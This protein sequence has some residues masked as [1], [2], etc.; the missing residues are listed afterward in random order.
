MASSGTGLRAG[1]P[2]IRTRFT[3]L[4]VLIM[5]IQK[6]RRLAVAGLCVLSIAIGNAASAANPYWQDLSSRNPAT[7]GPAPSAYR[8][9]VLDWNRLDTAMTTS[10]GGV[11]FKLDLPTP[12][13]GTQTF[14]LSDSGVMPAELAARYPSIR[15]YIGL[16]ADGTSARIDISELGLQASVYAKEG[17]WLVRPEMLG[18]GDHYLSFRRADLARGDH[19]RCATHGELE[20]TD[21]PAIEQ[22]PQPLTTTGASRRVYR[23]AVAANHQYVQAVA[24][25]MSPPQTPT[26]A[27]GLAAIVAA[28]NRVNQPYS[29]DFSIRMSLIATNDLLI[30]PDA[31]GDTFGSEAFNDGDALNQI[32]AAITGIVGVA[33]YDI[34]HLFTTGAG[35]VAGLGVVCGTSKG[36]GTTGLSSGST[37]QSDVFYIDYVAHE[38]GHQFGGNHTFNGANLPNN[39]CGSGNRTASSAY[40]PGSGSTIQA[41]AGICGVTMNLQL[42]SDPYFH[43]RSLAQMG[44]YTSTGNGG[45]CPASVVNPNAAPTI[46]PLPSY[47][48]PASTPYVLSGTASSTAAGATLTYAWEQYDLGPT[49][50]AQANTDLAVDPGTG[51]IQRSWPPTTAPRRF[52]PRVENLL[53]DTPAFGEILPTTSRLLTYRLTV[54]DNASDGG[55]SNST[56]QILTVVNTAGPF[57]VTAPL[58]TTPW[59][60][61]TGPATQTVTWN[62]AGTDLPP[63]SCA[64]VS[65]DL[66]SATS[67]DLIRTVLL[68]SSVPNSGSAVVTVPNVQQAAARVRVSCANNVFFN[69]SPAFAVTGSDLLFKNGFDSL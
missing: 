27:L 36:R 47:T 37:L 56:D 53:S 42:H 14:T 66:V 1:F 29:Q 40:E 21:Q 10:A 49:S 23:A 59:N 35:G 19:F 61:V 30:F 22:A 60:F 16:A 20:L 24:S 8:A 48:I 64:N 43:A 3:S 46:A 26:V 25:A 12:A 4:G 31:S 54:R 68:A 11:G 2:T 15:S 51:P 44:T 41:Y 7:L 50:I 62:V 28:M 39:N 13:G 17:I 18:R 9:V 34:G 52:L 67:T 38:I 57:V 32:T 65:I 45:T 63:V 5:T 6:L 55:T 58:A 69:V 33:N